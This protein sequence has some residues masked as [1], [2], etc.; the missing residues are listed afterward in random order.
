MAFFVSRVLATT[1]APK[2]ANLP[3]VDNDGSALRANPGGATVTWIGHSTLLIQ[4]DGVNLLT[5]PHWSNRASPVSFGGPP[6]ITP[7]GLG[8]EDLPPIHLVLISHDHYDH[9]DEATVKRLWATHRPR[10]LVPLGL[11]AWLA[12]RGI[13]D[14]EQLDWWE[15]RTEV[16]LT[17]TCLPAQHFSGRAF[18]DRNRRL[19]SGW[20]VAGRDKRL[21]F[22]GDTGYYDVFKEIG[23]RL[24]PFD[25]AAVPIGA[26]LPPV[27]MKMSHTT[28]EEALQV[29]LD[30]R[31]ERLVPIHWGTFDLAEEP[32]DEPPRRLAAEAR[33]LG[34]DPDRVWT[35][36]HGETRRW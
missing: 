19:W 28:P 8:F 15:S 6:R 10:F 31:G 4:L 9:L 5:D 30:V 34:L 13:S 20:S 2:T 22:A 23:A 36:K 29:L 26:Y 14:V 1:F 18:R 25:L 16:G 12:E 21:F 3:R 11:K 7:P 35:L 27:I 17:V 32:V 33:R 24:G